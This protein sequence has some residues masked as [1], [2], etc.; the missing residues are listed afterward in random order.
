M[1]DD[2][3]LFTRQVLLKL[4]KTFVLVIIEYE[5]RQYKMQTADWLQTIVFRVR[6]QWDH[7][8]LVL[9]SMVKTMVC[10]S[11]QSAFC[12]DQIHL[13]PDPGWRCIEDKPRQ[14]SYLRSLASLK[15][16]FS[17]TVC[18]LMSEYIQSLRH[19]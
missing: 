1:M 14:I 10:K 19:L 9:I 12:T 6:K 18:K 8:C 16:V 5:T 2:R 15:H 3:T 11:L 4:S 13:T 7:C 17:E